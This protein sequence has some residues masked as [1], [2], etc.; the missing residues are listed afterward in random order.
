MVD[1]LEL[2]KLAEYTEDEEQILTTLLLALRDPQVKLQYELSL[3]KTSTKWTLENVIEYADTFAASKPK[4]FEA[5]SSVKKASSR[6]SRGGSRGTGNRGFRGQGSRRPFGGSFGNRGTGRQKCQ[7]CGSWRH[8]NKDPRFCPAIGRHCNSCRG[9]DHFAHMCTDQS[10]RGQNF[11]NYGGAPRGSQ[12]DWQ[13]LYRGNRNKKV[14]GN[15]ERESQDQKE[16]QDNLVR[17]VLPSLA[18]GCKI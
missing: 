6:G 8:S 9:R 2:W 5:E 15:T 13:K 12:K 11:Q 3:L 18:A 16:R 4:S 7:A 10:A 17:E 1:I 14:D